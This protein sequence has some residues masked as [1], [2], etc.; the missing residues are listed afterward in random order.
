MAA[1]IQQHSITFWVT[2]EIYPNTLIDHL[3]NNTNIC[4]K[5]LKY[6]LYNAKSFHDNRLEAD[7]EQYP[8]IF[9]NEELL[10]NKIL[11]CAAWD[12]PEPSW[13]NIN[14]STWMAMNE[15]LNKY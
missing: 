2:I 10:P 14:R 1:L 13:F 4:Q 9:M 11:P 8:T 5:Y 7:Y 6:N 12:Q 15:L 3:T